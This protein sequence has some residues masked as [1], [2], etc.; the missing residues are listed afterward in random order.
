MAI[1]DHRSL[2]KTY[3]IIFTLQQFD[4]KYNFQFIHRCPTISLAKMLAQVLPDN[5]AS[6]RIVAG[7]TGPRFNTQQRATQQHLVEPSLTL[8]GSLLQQKFDLFYFTPSI[9]YFNLPF[10]RPRF[11]AFC[12][13]VFVRRQLISSLLPRSVLGPGLPWYKV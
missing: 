4:V 11:Q 6:Y 3:S 13:G 2:A 5:V 7:H 9:R 8:H 12:F 1:R 10:G